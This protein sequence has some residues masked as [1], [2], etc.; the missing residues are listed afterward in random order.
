[1]T[2][3]EKSGCADGILAQSLERLINQLK[4]GDREI[5]WRI[6]AFLAEE[7]NRKQSLD[8]ISRHLRS[9][10][11]DATA[12]ERTLETLQNIHLVDFEDEGYH[13]ASQSL[14]PRIHEWSTQQTALVQARQEAMNQ[15]KQMRNSALRGLLGGAI[16]FALFD[17][18]IYTGLVPDVLFLIQFIAT[19]TAIGGVM[20]F[21]LTLTIDLSIAAYHGSRLWMRY[22]VGGAGGMI[23]FAL[24]LILYSA[25]N[26]SGNL[27]MPVLLSIVVEGGLW[28]TVIGLGT[29]YVLGGNRSGLTFLAAEKILGGIVNENWAEAPSMLRIF[30]AGVLMPLCYTT[31]AL[32]RRSV[33]EKWS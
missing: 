7:E 32:F 30:L 9:Y 31:A 26:Y 24:G 3:Y 17:Q 11:V 12:T 1:M 20:G 13:L 6:L 23:A 15:L 25:N 8:G 33:Q 27:I 28:G 4:H 14:L 22:L 5:A 10:R 29:T 21:L 2:D 19:M 18:F 16:G